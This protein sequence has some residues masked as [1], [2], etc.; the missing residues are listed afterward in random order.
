MKLFDKTWKLAVSGA[1]IGLLVMLLA[2]YGNP[3]NMAICVACFIRDTAG[4]LKLH[5]A[6]PVQYFR[7]EVVGFVCGFVHVYLALLISVAFLSTICAV[8][9][10]DADCSGRYPWVLFCVVCNRGVNIL[11]QLL[12]AVFVRDAAEYRFTDDFSVSVDN[13]GGRE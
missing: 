9:V 2:I 7:P 12:H 5:T 3:A 11:L 4:A 8:Y 1:V 10:Y 13:I 6:A